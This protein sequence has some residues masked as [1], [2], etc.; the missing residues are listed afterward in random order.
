MA[1]VRRLFILLGLAQYF[2][3]ILLVEIPSIF[4]LVQTSFAA[5]ADYGWQRTRLR[6]GSSRIITYWVMSVA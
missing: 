4:K 1:L 5:M 2:R 3:F 6:D